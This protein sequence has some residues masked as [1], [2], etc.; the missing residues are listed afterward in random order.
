MLRR[1]SA[2][3]INI[4][5]LCTGNS[6]RSILAEALINALG[7]PRFNA[8]SAGSHPAGQ[9]DPNALA[10]LEQ[11]NLPTKSARSKSWDEF[12]GAAAPSIDIVITV[13]DQAASE[14][15]PLWPGSPITVHWGIPDP[16]FAT[17][18]AIEPAFDSTFSQ[19]KARIEGMLELPLESF[20]ARMR[21]ESLLRIHD[22][23]NLAEAGK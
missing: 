10:K 20:D 14:S 1:M 3:P 12:T 18:F 16:A 8:F 21:R 15:C 19:L 4:L 23:L 9:V 5:V 7:S 17:G 2:E 6:C 13:C 22:A 11:E